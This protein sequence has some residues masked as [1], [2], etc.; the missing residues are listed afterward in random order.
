MQRFF[1]KSKEAA[2][3]PKL[4]E[5]SSKMSEKGAD[6][7]KKIAECDAELLKLKAQMQNRVGAAGAKQRALTVLKRKKMYEQ[8][9][10]QLLGVQF[11]VDQM[12]FATE[13]MQTTLTTVEAMKYATTSLKQQM[14]NVNIDKLEEMQEDMA[15]LMMD[16]EEIQEVM[17]RNY[18]LDGIDDG[19]L[20]EEF[21]ALEEEIA[22]EQMDSKST[23]VPSY[24]PAA[25]VGPAEAVP[26]STTLA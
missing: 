24:L 12:Q 8:Q 16:H 15:E 22:L 21:A 7:E 11:N 14:Q 17:S 19:A 5:A 3:P 25:S 18:C 10:D 13:S 2:P 1:G 26:A 6:L 20:E 9:R 23:A 4:D